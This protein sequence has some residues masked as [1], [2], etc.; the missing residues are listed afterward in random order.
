MNDN[1]TILVQELKKSY[2]M[3]LCWYR[4]LGL[5]VQKILGKLILSRG[6]ISGLV[7]GLEK[8]QKILSSIENERN[9]TSDYVKHWQE[10]KNYVTNENEV[11]ELNLI[12]T[13]VE[14]AIKAFLNEEDQLKKYIERLVEKDTQDKDPDS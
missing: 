12:L 1:D 2:S 14:N 13:D 3:Q 9:R 8:K 4:E 5:L 10:R 7:S 6:D 11:Q